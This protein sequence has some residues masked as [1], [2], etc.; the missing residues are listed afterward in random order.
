MSVRDGLLCLK[1]GRRSQST[2]SSVDDP[3]LCKKEEHRPVSESEPV[4]ALFHGSCLQA[5]VYALTSMMAN[6]PKV[7]AK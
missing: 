7:Q 1:S 5:A 2:I 4:A 6:G 3:T